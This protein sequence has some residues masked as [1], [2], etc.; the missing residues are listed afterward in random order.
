M[1]AVT[2]PASAR[3]SLLGDLLRSR[4]ARQVLS[5]LLAVIGRNILAIAGLVM[6]DVGA[7][8]A[9]PVA[10]WLVTGGSLLVLDL[11]LRG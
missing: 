8:S 1:A 5:V 4:A 2:V 7:F 9:N 6:A 3:R 11:K 10:G